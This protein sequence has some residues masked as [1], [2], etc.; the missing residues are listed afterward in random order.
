[1]KILKIIVLVI[2][3]L[4]VLFFVAGLF[5]PKS[6]RVERSITLFQPV[7]MVY[8]DLSNFDLRSQWDPWCELDPRV[9]VTVSGPVG[10]VGS[11]WGWESDTLGKGSETIE[12]MVPDKLIRTK[13]EFMAPRHSISTML[14]EFEN[15]GD[16]VRFSWVMTGNVRY[17]VEIWI[18]L[19]MDKIIGKDLERGLKNIKAFSEERAA[20]LAK[21]KTGDVVEY[22]TEPMM[23]LSIR[24]KV[25]MDE[26][27][28]KIG[29][30]YGEL[31]SLI[32][33][34][35]DKE[36]G[37]PFARYFSMIENGEIDMEAG[38]PVKNKYHGSG[39]VQFA[40][41]P[42]GKAVAAIHYGPYQSI[43][44]TYETLMTYIKGKGYRTDHVSMEIYITDPSTVK[45]PMKLET[46]V[47][48]FIR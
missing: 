2:L 46:K 43:A 40:K 26:I 27:A 41:L 8:N 14:Y 37:Y 44:T 10:E 9:K 6:Y 39:R 36:A 23:Y 4:L 3:G 18:G 20:L 5:L 38:I 22:I 28:S 25:R 12:E 24:Q 45:D 1:M 17:P 42:S 31:M 47:V 29:E 15:L 13:L 7:G 19:L 33:Q 32:Q 30:F 48:F 21:G 34:S 16:S 35:G 11:T